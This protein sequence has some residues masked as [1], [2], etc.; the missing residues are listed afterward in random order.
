M[1]YIAF[2]E[3]RRKFKLFKSNTGCLNVIL[4]VTGT[5][6]ISTCY[7]CDWSQYGVIDIDNFSVVA[8]QSSD[9]WTCG[10]G[11]ERYLFDHNIMV[12][13]KTVLSRH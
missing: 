9:S 6:V 13:L 8:A 4:Q 1:Y 3:H 10:E 2:V 12:E 11:N 7:L 5:T